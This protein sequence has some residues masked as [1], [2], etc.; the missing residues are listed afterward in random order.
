MVE[1]ILEFGR[2]IVTRFILDDERGTAYQL[3][4]DEQFV[5]LTRNELRTL[6]RFFIMDPD[7][8]MM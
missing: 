1:D 6:I 5:T 2:I 8:Q 4:V 7:F 3:R